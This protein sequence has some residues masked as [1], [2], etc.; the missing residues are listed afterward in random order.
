MINKYSFDI[1]SSPE[2]KQYYID[3]VNA[4]RA[5]AYEIINQTMDILQNPEK[6]AEILAQRSELLAQAEGKQVLGRLVETKA[7]DL[8]IADVGQASRTLEKL[9]SGKDVLKETVKEEPKTVEI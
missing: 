5:S 9:E 6:K 2:K 1:T 4:A 7:L 8:G 3:V